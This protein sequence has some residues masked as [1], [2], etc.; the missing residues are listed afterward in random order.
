VPDLTLCAT[1]GCPLAGGCYRKLAPHGRWQSVSRF[2]GGMGCAYFL[3][4]EEDDPS[5]A[6]YADLRARL[7]SLGP[8]HADAVRDLLDRLDGILRQI[9]VSS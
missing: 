9:R 4:A 5:R 1:E 7:D 3:P 6:V 2:D 8:E